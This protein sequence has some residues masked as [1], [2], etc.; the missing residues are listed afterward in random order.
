MIQ[1]INQY[2]LK[3]LSSGQE[4]FKGDVAIDV[5]LLVNYSQIEEFDYLHNKIS[6]L[7]ISIRWF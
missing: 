1:K 2:P 5:E 6:L 4:F 3:E 7:I